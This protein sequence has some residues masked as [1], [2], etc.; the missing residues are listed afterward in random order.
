MIH[1]SRPVEIFDSPVTNIPRVKFN[2]A[3]SWKCRF[4]CKQ[5]DVEKMTRLFA[6]PPTA[7]CK[8][9][10]LQNLFRQVLD[11]MVSVKAIAMIHD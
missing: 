2:Y 5:G 4:I 3:V 8:G 7:K 1:L 9:T 10:H 6:I 11:E